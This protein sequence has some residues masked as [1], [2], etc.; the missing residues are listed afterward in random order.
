[1]PNPTCLIGACRAQTRKEPTCL[2]R[3]AR[4]RLR[5]Q[6]GKDRARSNDERP[7]AGWVHLPSAILFQCYFQS[8]WVHFPSAILFQSC[9]R[10]RTAV[11]WTG[12]Q[13]SG[14][15]S[16]KKG[17]SCQTYRTCGASKLVRASCPVQNPKAAAAAQTT[18]FNLNRFVHGS[19]GC[20]AASRSPTTVMDYRSQQSSFP[21]PCSISHSL[22]WIRSRKT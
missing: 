10:F 7:R 14:T 20:S 18:V 4:S 13:P 6:G 5:R 17:E 2:A 1:M 11:L 16:Y 3:A 19:D 22:R 15:G 21:G 8:G 12:V 9:S